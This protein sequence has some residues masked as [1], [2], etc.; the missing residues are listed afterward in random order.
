MDGEQSN[1]GMRPHARQTRPLVTAAR[2]WVIG[3][4]YLGHTQGS[5]AAPL[6]VTVVLPDGRPLSGVVV[7]ARPT[8]GSA[9][10]A[11]PAQAIMDQVDKAFVP[12]LLVIS[13]GSTV[14]FPNSDSVSHQIYSFSPAKRFQLPL[15]RGKPYPPVEF[16]QAG[17]VT[18]GCNIH[19]SMLA[20]VVV[21]DAPFF[22]RTNITG[23]WTHEVAEGRYQVT[24]WHP[25]LRDSDPKVLEGE[26]S[27]TE[28]NGG[29]LTL[30]LAKPLKPA[31]LEGPAHSWD[32]Y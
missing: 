3:L 21:T 13:T 20:Y 6:T 25:R 12:D 4:A 15:Y 16:D 5:W 17:V 26:V 32:V 9:H 2:A 31:P 8:T 14:G 1:A 29:T 10:A 19:D 7:T 23:S 27:V 11:A 30:H 22:G 24:I 18:L 28:P